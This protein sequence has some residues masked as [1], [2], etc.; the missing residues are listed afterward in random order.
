M[1]ISLK[2]FKINC[3]QANLVSKFQ[4]MALGTKHEMKLN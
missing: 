3:L 1:T 4:I 2:R